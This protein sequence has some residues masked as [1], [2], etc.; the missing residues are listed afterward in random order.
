[1][2]AN[3]M[4]AGATRPD[5]TTLAR[6]ISA[7]APYDGSFD[8][9][10]PNV[11][12]IKVSRPSTRATHTMQSPSV[13][14]VAQGAKSVMIGDDV[15]SYEAAQVAVFSVDIPVAAQVTRATPGEPYL[16]LKI[17]LD[18]QKITDLAKRAFPNGLPQ[19]R[20][21]RPLYIGDADPHMIDAATRLI[22]LMDRPANAELIAP[23]VIDEILIRLLVSPM[24][25][26]IAQMGL[27]DSNFHRVAK[28]VSWLRENFDQPADVE[29]LARLVN[30]SLSAFH[31]QFRAVTSM[32]PLQFQKALRL[33]EARR[34]MLASMLDASAAGRRVGYVSASQFSREYGRFFGSAPARDIH[35][36]REEGHAAEESP[37]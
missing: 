35:R 37:P 3:S 9:R 23:L 12:A 21:S 33:Q 34:L 14:I 1:M 8:L 26:R 11:H 20:D 22:T 31:R 19:A 10:I 18:P 25:P 30:M 24:G 6:L 29:A 27:I 36:L 16:T 17:D 13:C 32:S 15:Y 28:A 4:S 2:A 7:H 5:V